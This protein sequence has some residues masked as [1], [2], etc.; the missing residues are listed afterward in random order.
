MRVVQL[1]PVIALVVGSTCG[2]AS[3][4][5]SMDLDA[6]GQ[7]DALFDPISN[8]T[9]LKNANVLGPATWS[10]AGQWAADYS[11]GAY[12]AWRLPSI[13]ELQALT[14]AN[15]FHDVLAADFDNL[16]FIYWS[17]QVAAVP[18]TPSALIYTMDFG[19]VFV[20]FQTPPSATYAWAVTDGAVG[21]PIGVPEPAPVFLLLGA[22]LASL[23]M[24][25]GASASLRTR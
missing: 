6:D 23:L 11:I 19:N 3:L 7:P 10:A 16:Q 25:G 18:G 13:A 12:A 21:V 5:Q 24:R 15:G 22:A 1:V 2:H 4:L 9:W 14:A 17:N 20:Q 8:L